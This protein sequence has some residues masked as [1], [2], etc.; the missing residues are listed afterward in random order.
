VVA[1]LI[2]RISFEEG[3][4]GSL[5]LGELR[6]S[7]TFMERFSDRLLVSYEERSYGSFL[8]AFSY[9]MVVVHDDSHLLY[10]LPWSKPQEE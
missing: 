4:I 6:P 5:I 1:S 9:H 2:R 10:A 3:D 8:F 7:S